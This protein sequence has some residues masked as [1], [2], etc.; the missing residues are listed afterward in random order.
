MM[1]QA[2]GGRGGATHYQTYEPQQF[3]RHSVVVN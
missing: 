1:P 3:V 2:G